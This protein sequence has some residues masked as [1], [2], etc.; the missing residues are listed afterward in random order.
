MVVGSLT[1]LVS[2]FWILYDQERQEDSDLLRSK[3]L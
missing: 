3:L 2:S 1:V